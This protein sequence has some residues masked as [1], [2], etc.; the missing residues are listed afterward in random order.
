VLAG[1]FEVHPRCTACGLRFDR[2]EPGY[3]VGAGCLNLI[4]AE[5]VFALGLLAA[6]VFTWPNPPWNTM[7]YAGI[8]VMALM[9]ILFFP[10]SR[11]I[12]IAFDLTFRPAEP[13]D[14]SATDGET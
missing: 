5:L 13:H 8:P 14:D 7:L 6:L 12:W 2:G 10:F 1:W 3:F 4:V 11:T 9:P